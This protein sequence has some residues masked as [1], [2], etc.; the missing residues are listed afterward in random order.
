MN[1]YEYDFQFLFREVIP[2]DTIKRALSE[3][4][5]I[6]QSKIC[7]YSSIGDNDDDDVLYYEYEV[8]EKGFKLFLTLHMITQ[9]WSRF[10]YKNAI[11]DLGLILAKHL[12][13]ELVAAPYDPI[14]PYTSDWL[15]IEPSSLIYRVKEKY[16]D[17]DVFDIS[18][19]LSLLTEEEI[20]KMKRD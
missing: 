11:L 13:K 1:E 17:E 2:L 9:F 14:D 10:H 5:L 7:P 18:D 4:F 8:N 19:E 20:E 16:P 12:G 3:L 15:L 6:P